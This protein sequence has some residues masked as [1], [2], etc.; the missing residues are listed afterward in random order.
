MGDNLGG[1]KRFVTAKYDYESYPPATCVCV[2]GGG[3]ACDLRTLRV[4]RSV[5]INNRSSIQHQ[6]G[7]ARSYL[8]LAGLIMLP[9]KNS[10]Y[11]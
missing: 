4:V 6:T 7:A 3:V 1:M 9:A 5:S 11:R 2:G 8:I 10:P